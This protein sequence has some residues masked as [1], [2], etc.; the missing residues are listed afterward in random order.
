MPNYFYIYFMRNFIGFVMIWLIILLLSSCSSI[1]P[2][3]N[4]GRSHDESMKMR[5]KIIKKE[6][7]RIKKQMKKARVSGRK[8]VAKSRNNK[9]KTKIIT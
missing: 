4:Q 1:G 7:A 9:S 2:N 6:D 3:Y 8:I 5:H